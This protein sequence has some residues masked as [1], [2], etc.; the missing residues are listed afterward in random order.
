MRE[1]GLAGRTQWKRIYFIS[2]PG[3]EDTTRPDFLQAISID[4]AQAEKIPGMPPAEAGGSF[5]VQPRQRTHS[6]PLLNATSGSWWI[7][8]VQPRQRTHS[9]PLLNATSGSWWIVQVQPRQ[10]THSNP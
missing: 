1:E 9:N 2:L 8:Q 10:R 4:F 3:V 5:Q 6:N 7:V